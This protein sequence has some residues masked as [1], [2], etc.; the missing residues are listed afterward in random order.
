MKDYQKLLD[1]GWAIQLHRTGD[2]Y[3]AVGISRVLQ[4]EMTKMA[5]G[6]PYD[7]DI[8]H[9]AEGDTPEIAL[10]LLVNKVFFGRS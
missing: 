7:L 5:Q 2:T 1:N 4:G 3:T 6:E 9:F 8:R 10:E